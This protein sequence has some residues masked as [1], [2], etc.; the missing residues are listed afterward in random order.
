M[1][2]SRTIALRRKDALKR[3][4][5]VTI[6]ADK[7]IGKNE[8]EKIYAEMP[9]NSEYGGGSRGPSSTHSSSSQGFTLY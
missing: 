9:K 3:S 7:I 2:T 4:K 5:Q 1:V 8:C 6:V